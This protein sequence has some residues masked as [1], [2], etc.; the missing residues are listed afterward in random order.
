VPFAEAGCENQ[1]SF[2]NAIL[3]RPVGFSEREA[4]GS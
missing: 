4:A 2:H 1:N 3:M